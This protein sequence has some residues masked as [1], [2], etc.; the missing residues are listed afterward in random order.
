MDLIETHCGKK[1]LLQFVPSETLLCLDYC[2]IVDD[3]FNASLKCSADRS[4][5]RLGSVSRVSAS[6]LNIDEE[7]FACCLYIALRPS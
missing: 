5:M 2:E 6:R 4:S 7:P 1:I 3:R